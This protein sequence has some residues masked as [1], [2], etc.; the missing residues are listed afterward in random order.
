[1]VN[2]IIPKNGSVF[3]Q[4]KCV[5]DSASLTTTFVGD[6][7]TGSGE[8]TSEFVFKIVEGKYNLWTEI[9]FKHPNSICSTKIIETNII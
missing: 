1:M 2:F 3:S 5:K 4:I 8:Y 7:S 6:A 9:S